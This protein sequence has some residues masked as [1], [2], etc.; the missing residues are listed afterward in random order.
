VGNTY[1]ANGNTLASGARTYSYDSQN[2]LVSFNGGALTMVYDGDGNRV[3]KNATQYL[4]DEN[5]PTGLPQV[6]EELSGGLVQA[7]Y[8]Y[9]LER[10]SQTRGGVTSYYGSDAHG[11]VRFLMDGSGAVTDTYEYDAWGNLTNSTGTTTNV[12]LYQG[13]QYDAETKLYYFRARYFDSLTGR[14]LSVDPLAAQ[15]QRPYL[16][17]GGDPVNGHDPTGSE[18]IIAYS[19]L[20]AAIALP[21]ADYTSSI[22]DDLVCLGTLALSALRAP[23]VVVRVNGCKVQSVD[24]NPGTPLGPPW[25]GPP[26][27]NKRCRDVVQFPE[28]GSDRQLV[29]LR[30]INENSGS[31]LFKRAYG[32]GDTLGN[33]TGP[34]VTWLS[35]YV[36]DRYFLTVL[37]NR[38]N[39]RLFRGWGSTLGQ[40]A[41]NAGGQDFKGNEYPVGAGI[42]DA[43]YNGPAKSFACKDVAVALSAC[44][45]G[46][47][48]SDIA[49]PFGPL[50]YWKG[51]LQ[52][53]KSKHT[54]L[55]PFRL[56]DIRVNN[57]DFSPRN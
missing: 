50:L 52:Q 24:S 13:E 28:E 57:T 44:D 19:L 53:T 9:G 32:I 35:I 23:G 7:T 27:G 26:G 8:V 39:S 3:A 14:F 11:D 1:D 43:A 15:G 21:P 12:Y 34:V 48:T 5:N 18:N 55:V 16:Y 17:A 20:L 36:E 47:M 10:I 37:T 2:R 54:I 30:L 56:G 4:V 42:Y 46:P 6:V 29:V 45:D 33:P 25:P 49:S 41:K 51:I 38:L 22:H 31:S 40:Q